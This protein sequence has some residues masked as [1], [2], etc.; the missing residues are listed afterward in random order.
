M[1]PAE[2]Y[3]FRPNRTKLA[4]IQFA[5]TTYVSFLNSSLLKFAWPGPSHRRDGRKP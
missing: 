1:C 2:E 3:A 5:R 4:A